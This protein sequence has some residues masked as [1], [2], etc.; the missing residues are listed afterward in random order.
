MHFVGLQLGWDMANNQNAPVSRDAN[1]PTAKKSACLRSSDK[2]WRAGFPIRSVKTV[3]TLPFLKVSLA[4]S[5]DSPMLSTGSTISA[6]AARV[7][8]NS[9]GYRWKPLGGG[10]ERWR[11]LRLLRFCFLP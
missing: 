5:S 3:L 4:A 6:R 8:G 1:R 11:R 9:V 2:N 7:F 10:T